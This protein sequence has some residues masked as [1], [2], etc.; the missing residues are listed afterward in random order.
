VPPPTELL[1]RVAV[2]IRPLRESPAFRRVWLGQSISFLGRRMTIVVLPVQVYHL[3]GSVLWVGLLSLAQ[4]VPLITLTLVGGVFA[5]SVDRRRLLAGTEIGMALSVAG[6]VVNA[7]L[8]HPQLWACFVFGALSWAFFSFGAGAYR[9]LAPRLVPPDQFAAASALNSLYG[10]LGSVVGPAVAGLLISR[11]G[12]SATYGIDLATSTAGLLS[13]LSLPAIAPLGEAAQPGLR[14][15]VEGF[16]F[17]RSQRVVLGFFLLDSLAMIFGMPNALFPAL[18]KHVFADPAA[19]GFL[20]AA[21][22][23]GALA[24]ALLSGWAGGLRRQGV[25]IVV[26]VLVWGGAITLFGFTSELWLAVLLLA[27]AGAGDQ[28]SAI[29][30]STIMLSV[31]PDHLRGR[32]GGIEFAQVASTPSLGNLEAGVVASLTSLRVSIV[33]GGL[34]CIAAAIAVVLLFPSLLR[35]DARKAMSAVRA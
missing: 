26:A 29:F 34:A 12:F 27:V 33:S 11:I 31:T 6:L 20:Y 28:I 21:P 3:T 1:R 13:I 19:V 22:A 5:D 23:A 10:Q 30:R 15:L 18:A 4:F 16:R 35:Y 17:V 25:A 7:A 24:A 8:P 2:D 32:L 14:A 9:S